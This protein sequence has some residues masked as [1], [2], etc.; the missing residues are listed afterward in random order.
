M[1]LYFWK[2]TPPIYYCKGKT[3]RGL[4]KV[5]V[6]KGVVCMVQ[7]KA[8]MDEKCMIEWLNK[9]WLPYVGKNRAP[10]LGYILSSFN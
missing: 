1:L 10:L 9:V 5:Q 6:P 2:D 7:A 8:W 4:K 3:T